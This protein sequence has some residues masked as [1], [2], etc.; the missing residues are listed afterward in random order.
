MG[1]FLEKPSQIE[2]SQGIEL[3]LIAKNQQLE[4]EIQQRKALE[5][6]LHILSMVSEQSPVS[7]VITDVDGNIEYVNPKFTEISGYSLEEVIG[8]NPRVLKSGHTSPEDYQKLWQQISNGQEWRGEFHNRRKNGELYWEAASISPIKDENG[9]IT[10][11][12]AVKEDITL[13]KLQEERLAHQ[14]HYDALTDLPNRVLGMDRLNQALIQAERQGHL[15]AVMFVDLDHF[16]D[17]NDIFGHEIGDYLLVEA[18][19]RLSSCVRKSDTVARLGGDEFLVILPLVSAFSSVELIAHRI[20]DSIQLPFY[21]LGKELFV[22]TSIGIALYP[23]DGQLSSVLMR[24]ADSAMYQS[25]RQGRNMFSCYL[26]NLYEIAEHRLKIDYHLRYAQI[27]NELKLFYQPLLDLVSGKV[28]GAEALIR[29]YNPFLGWI[30][31]EEFIP[32][33][34]EVGLIFELGEWTLSQACQMLKKWQTQYHQLFWIAVNVS[35]R[36]LHR[37]NFATMVC[38]I[39]EYLQVSSHCLEI[40]ITEGCLMEDTAY[41]QQLLQ[42]LNEAQI[43]LSI[44]DFGTGFASLNYLHRFPFKTLKI[45]RSFIAEIPHKA[46]SVALVK[47]IIAIAKGLDMKIVAEGVETEEQLK[48]LQQEQCDYAQGYLFCKPVSAEDFET[49]LTTSSDTPFYQMP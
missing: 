31:P 39:L 47:T 27:K 29:W 42:Q 4:Q 49:Y 3:E 8:Q 33:A 44:D 16:K 2:R 22:S 28:V 15:V 14:A 5:K 26:P 23:R 43:H 40:E 30:S 25:K 21:L 35:P 36:Q 6:R 24:N 18:A 41:I 32:I 20:L 45:D 10:H 12:V 37:P 19:K 13:R 38:Q 11:F 34:E 1:Q 7:I 17:I 48:F 9:V 46:D